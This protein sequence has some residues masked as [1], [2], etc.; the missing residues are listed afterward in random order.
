MSFVKN[1]CLPLHL[2]GAWAKKGYYLQ[3]K[4]SNGNNTLKFEGD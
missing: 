1:A 2:I 3:N 4:I